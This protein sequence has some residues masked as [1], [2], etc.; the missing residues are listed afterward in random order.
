MLSPL[1]SQRELSVFSNSYA[2][3][4]QAFLGAVSALGW[5]VEVTAL[6]YEGHGPA[7]ESLASQQVWIGA[8]DAPRVLVLLSAVHGIEGFCG[9]AI[10]QDLVRRL[11]SGQ[12]SVPEGMAVLL[13]HAVNP[14]GF[15]WC[16]RVDEQGID[17]NRNFVDFSQALPDNA[18]YRE[19][20]S[21]LVPDTLVPS[22]EQLAQGEHALLHYLQRHGQ[23][24]YELA[25]SGGQYEFADGLFYGGRAPCQARLNLERVLATL[26]CANRDV[27]VVDL[28]T[29]LGPYG[30][31]ELICDHPLDSAGLHT[32][33]RWYGD[34]VTVPESGDSCS[35]PKTGLVD[36]A[37]HRVMG[38]RSC[39]VTLEFGTYPIAELLRCLRADH[40]LRRPGQQ[41][42]TLP[43]SE[44]VR[45]QLLKQFYPAESQWQTL[46]LLRGRQVIQM[47][48]QGLMHG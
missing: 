5:P 12:L 13:V 33:Q 17:V 41:P 45:L 47:A 3:A 38:P 10:Q 34:S 15:A 42:F 8:A 22:V 23:Y 16:R 19:L 18:G 4:E 11:S 36:Y 27:A 24:E 44:E 31:G 6:P 46:V 21:A 37:F 2:E 9:S 40:R 29:G 48:S 32:A 1:L 7:G 39:Y 26:D 43:G 35:V 25:V 28:H 20:A 30:Y 14:W